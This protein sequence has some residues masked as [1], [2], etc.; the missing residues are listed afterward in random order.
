MKNLNEKL[1]KF[2]IEKLEERKEFTFY[3]CVPKPWYQPQPTP[4]PTPYIPPIIVNPNPDP[5][6]GGGEVFY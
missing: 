4:A 6:T 5:G 3:Y 2:S 1:A